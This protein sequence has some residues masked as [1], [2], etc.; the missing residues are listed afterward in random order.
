MQFWILTVFA[1][2][3]AGLDQVTKYLTVANIPLFGHVDFLPGVLGLTYV[4]N[5]GAAWSM[6]QGMRWF[7]VALF[8]ALTVAIL[9]E[10]FKSPMPFSKFDRWCIA[11]VYGGGF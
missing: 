6:M 10:Y 1:L 7:F 4:Q 3:V 2:V 5:T 9:W 11:A 8:L